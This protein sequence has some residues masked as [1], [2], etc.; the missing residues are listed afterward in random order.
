MSKLEELINKLCPNGVRFEKINDVLFSIRSGLNPGQNFRLNTGGSFNYVTIKEIATGKIVFSDKTG[1]ID[2]NAWQK[3]QVRSCLEKG[4]VLLSM[5]GTIGKVA[6]VDIETNNWNCSHNI[7]L[8]KPNKKMVTSWY[9]KYIL[10]LNLFR[11]TLIVFLLVA[12]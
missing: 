8:L 5:I 4:D 7:L 6:V 12:F 3:I 9:L 10:N 11:I 1:K 2:A